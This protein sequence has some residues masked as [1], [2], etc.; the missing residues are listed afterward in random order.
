MELLNKKEFEDYIHRNYET[1]IESYKAEISD[2]F[3]DTCDACHR[4]AFLNIYTKTF[5]NI[6]SNTY[7]RDVLPRFV[8]F[9]VECPFCR[10]KSF[11]LTV[12]VAISKTVTVKNDD[13]EDEEENVVAYQY[14]KIY[15][16]P[17]MEEDFANSD[18]PEGYKSLKDTVS[19]ASFCLTHSRFVASAILFRRAIQILAKDILGAQGRGLSSQLEWLKLNKNLLGIELGVVFHDNAKIIKNIGDQGAHPDNDIT[20]HNFTREDADGLHDLFISIVT[21][22]FVKPAKMQA[23]QEELKKSRKLK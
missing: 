5:S 19:E 9:F 22:V 12:E 11:I 20:L 16:L 8:T 21:E 17:V 13:G 7:H 10:R 15:R 1:I 18:I 14:Y 2:V 6:Y 4:E 3:P 23:I